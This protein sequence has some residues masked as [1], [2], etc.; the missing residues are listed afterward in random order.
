[1][2][3]RARV[4][5]FRL[6]RKVA[7]DLR[8]LTVVV[9][10]NASGRSSFLEALGWAV[11]GARML[12]EADPDGLWKAGRPVLKLTETTFTTS[13]APYPML[14]HHTRVDGYRAPGKQEFELA[15]EGNAMLM[16]VWRD[17]RRQDLL[18]RMRPTR[19]QRSWVREGPRGFTLAFSA[20]RLSPSL[21]ALAAPAPVR[22]DEVRLGADGRGL[23][24][25]LHHLARAGRLEALAADLARVVPGVEGVVVD[26]LPPPM[27]G[28]PEH[29]HEVELAVRFAGQGEIPTEALSRGTLFALAFLA[30]LHWEAHD[31]L[32]LDDID[33][34]LHPAAQRALVRAIREALARRPALQVIATANAPFVLAELDAAEVLV[35]AVD[36][37]GGGAR[38]RSGRPPGLGAP[39]D[40]L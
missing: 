10:P 18:I 7:V 35:T 29:A 11:E 1:M 31:L 6:L 2:I 39:A 15:G 19:N 4:Q 16:R 38:F 36:P 22:D 30:A 13:S 34:G 24:A 33:A 23:A 8:R 40:D 9:G 14:R 27:H 26:R 3:E 5:N 12:V 20:L 17:G 28:P 32:L 37:E 25:L 21:G